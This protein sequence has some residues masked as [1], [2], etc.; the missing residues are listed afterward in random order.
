MAKNPGYVLERTTVFYF[1]GDG[2]R[3]PAKRNPG[4]ATL[5]RLLVRSVHNQRRQAEVVKRH[6]TGV[7]EHG[8]NWESRGGA[9][10]HRK[11]M[12]GA[13]KRASFGRPLP[14]LRW[15]ES[16]APAPGVRLP[17]GVPGPGRGRRR[18][19]AASSSPAHAAQE[20][21]RRRG[22][23]GEGRSGKGGGGEGG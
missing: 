1:E 12:A 2:P 10:C 21:G 4:T 17:G 6:A 22:Q 16:F 20:G 13:T 8:A 14:R 9:I 3:K 7:L 11:D 18:R 19:A 23:A 5:R 15:G